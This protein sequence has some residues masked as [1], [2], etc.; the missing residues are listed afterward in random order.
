MSAVTEQPD[1]VRRFT[2]TEIGFPAWDDALARPPRDRDQ[3]QRR[4]RQAWAHDLSDGSWRQMSDEPVGVEVTWMLPGDRVAWW[5]DTT[6]DERGL[7][8]A[9]PF[10]GGRAEPVFPS[11]PEGWLM[12]HSFEAGIAA[13]S[14]EIGGAYRTT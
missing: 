5:R 6:G 10:A 7:L 14:M 3:P 13:I 11:L 9:M 4:S 2:A 8:M 1:W 12:G